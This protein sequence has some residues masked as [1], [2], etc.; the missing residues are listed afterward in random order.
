MVDDRSNREEDEVQQTLRDLFNAAAAMSL[1]VTYSLDGEP[2]MARFLDAV[3]AHPE[4]RAF[5]VRLFLD[6]FSEG[7]HMRHEPTDFM[8]YCMS[9]LRWDEIRDFIR[10]KRDEDV[11]T[12][13]VACY[14]I[15]NGILESFQDNWR[16]KYFQDFT[17]RDSARGRCE[18]LASWHSYDRPCSRS[19]RHAHMDRTAGT[20]PSAEFSR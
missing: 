6:S 20:T 18:P 17:K 5:V 7:F 10:R 3:K 11:E 4:Q 8:M 2:E 13:G 14:G 19:R 16:M 15:W 9:D 12:H 1:A